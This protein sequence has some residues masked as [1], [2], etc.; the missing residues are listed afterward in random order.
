MT[1]KQLRLMLA[2]TCVSVAVGWADRVEAQTVTALYALDCGD[3][4]TMDQSQFSPG[5]GV[6]KKLDL[7][8]TCWV[9]RHPGGVLL[10]DTGVPDALAAQ[11]DG[12]RGNQYHVR[13]KQTLIAQLATLNLTPDSIDYLGMS[14][15]HFDHAG[16]ANLFTAPTWLIQRPEYE[17]AFS[18]RAQQMG[19][20]PVSYEK[21]KNGKVKQLNGD[22]DVFGDSS[23]VILSTPGH[24]IGHQSLL[25]RLPGGNQV[26]LSGDLWHFRENRHIRGVPAFNFDKTQTLTSMDRVERLLEARK[27]RLIIQHD[28]HDIAALGRLPAAVR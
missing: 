16:N 8:N 28:P 19:F 23:V 5:V 9:V 26:L 22:H 17:A 12:I 1:N 3:I 4:T 15:L 10:W 6:G 20:D 24:T 25:V 2:L 11:A 7:T 21:L 13:R 27:A 14:H 18:A